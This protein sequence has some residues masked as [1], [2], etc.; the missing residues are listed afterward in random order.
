[1]TATNHQKRPA[2]ANAAAIARTLSSGHGGSPYLNGPLQF[3]DSGNPPAPNRWYYNAKTDRF[4]TG[5]SC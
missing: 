1:M 3:I 2:G 4:T 5:A